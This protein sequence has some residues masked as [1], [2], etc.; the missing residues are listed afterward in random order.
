MGPWCYPWGQFITVC[1]VRSWRALLCAHLSCCGSSCHPSSC[2]SKVVQVHNDGLKGAG[3]VVEVGTVA[4]WVQPWCQPFGE[5]F[6]FGGD[7]RSWRAPLCAPLSH[8]G[9]SCRPS[10]GHSS[11]VQAQQ[12]GLTVLDEPHRWEQWPG[13]VMPA[14]G[15]RSQL[16]AV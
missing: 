7:V 10:R 8:Q 9:S 15:N 6:M 16:S 2:Y 12:R 3:R 5:Q 11:A 14:S 13:M 1:D 4:T